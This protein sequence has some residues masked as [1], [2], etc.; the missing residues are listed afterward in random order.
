M[1][2]IQKRHIKFIVSEYV[3]VARLG[4]RELSCRTQHCHVFRALSCDLCVES[5]WVFVAAL[6]EKR[7]N[8]SDLKCAFGLQFGRD[9]GVY[10][11]D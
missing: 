4:I 10:G 5:L 6:C 7:Y 11:R 3:Q 8:V 1:V 2:C 9:V